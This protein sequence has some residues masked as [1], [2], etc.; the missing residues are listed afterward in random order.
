[1][2]DLIH[3]EQLLVGQGGEGDGRDQA[4]GD[5]LKGDPGSG[6]TGQGAGQH[7]TQ[8]GSEQPGGE[9]HGRKTA[10]NPSR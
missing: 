3:D 10:S 8:G 5:E 4:F 7:Q 9:F 6:G 2:A 1:M